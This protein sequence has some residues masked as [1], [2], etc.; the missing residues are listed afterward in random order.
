MGSAAMQGRLW[1][2]V[3]ARETKAAVAEIDDPAIPPERKDALRLSSSASRSVAQDEGGRGQ[4][5]WG[6]R[7]VAR[8]ASHPDPSTPPGADSRGGSITW[9]TA[10]GNE[11]DT[12]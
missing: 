8:T 11:H 3:Q 10:R 12:V 6:R 4:S 5:T 1:A 2:P 7:G 9:R